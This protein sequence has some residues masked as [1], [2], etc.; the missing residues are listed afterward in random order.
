M[1]IFFSRHPSTLKNVLGK[2]DGN[3]VCRDLEYFEN[4]TTQHQRILL[5]VTLISI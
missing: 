2:L 3:S 5:H 1:P 4:L